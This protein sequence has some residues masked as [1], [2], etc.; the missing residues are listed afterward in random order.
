MNAVAADNILTNPGFEDGEMGDWFPYGEDHTVELVTEDPHS[1]S[2]CAYV[3]NRTDE[4]NGV[5]QELVDELS[6]GTYYTFSAW[7]K[8]EGSEEADII[9]S[10]RRTEG[11]GEPN[12]ERISLTTVEGG[13]W[14][15]ISGTYQVTGSDLTELQFYVEGPPAERNFYV[16][17]VSVVS[18]G[19]ADDWEEEANARIEELRKRDAQIKVVDENNQPVSGITVNASQLKHHFGFGSALSTDSMYSQEYK[20]FFKENYEWAVFENAAKWYSNEP[21]KGNYNYTNADAMYE[22]CEE[23]DIKVR[24][25]CIFWA[26]D[27]FVPSWVQ[28]LS[29]QELREAV[30][31]RLERAVNHWDG[32]FLH[33]DVNNEMLHGDFFARNLG[34]D[35]RADMFKKTRELDPEAELYVNDYNVITEPETDAYVR[36][37]QG[38]LDQDAPIDGIGVQGHFGETV[39]PIIVKSRLDRLAQFDLPIWVTEFDTEVADVNQRAD[40]LE[41]LYRLAFSHPAVEGIMM[42]GFWANDH[43]KGADAALVDSDWTINEA[44]IR[45][46]QLMEEWT[47]DTSGTTNSSGAFEFSGFHGTYEV[48]I[49]VPGNEPVVKTLEL[50]PGQSV[51]QLT[52]S[53]DGE[54]IESDKGDLN[55]DGQIDS[56]DI[57]SMRRYLSGSTSELPSV[58]AADMNSDGYIDSLD[59]TLLRRDIV[60]R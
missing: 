7:V 29:T 15:E 25:H 56:L 37:I 39:D 60:G 57:T 4:W 3:S 8:L 44:G 12:F 40:N 32:K 30:D 43:W 14:V 59:Y 54:E 50:E 26:V 45:Y 38:L 31:S 42:W 6:S 9:M 47:T 23:N 21:S 49:D 28:N 53:V 33:W 48:T 2:Y 41:T 22:F 46:Q 55:N 52:L 20:D 1:G 17:D 58:D 27:R 10:M 13:E 18:A 35:I 19:T 5:S 51:K 36:Q 34:E 24:G 11:E 16:D